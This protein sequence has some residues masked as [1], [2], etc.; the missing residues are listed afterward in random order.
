MFYFPVFFVYLS[1]Y[2]WKIRGS[3]YIH[4]ATKICQIKSDKISTETDQ[5]KPIKKKK[6]KTDNTKNFESTG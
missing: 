6:K 5:K 3:I 2:S 4:S 1:L